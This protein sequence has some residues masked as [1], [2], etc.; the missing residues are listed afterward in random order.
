MTPRHAELL[1][2]DLDDETL[3]RFVDRFLMF[4]IRTAD[5]LQ[6][7]APWVEEKGLEHVREVVCDDSLGLAAEFEAAVARH[8][9]GYAC[10][11][12]GVLEDPDKLSRFVSFVNAPGVDDPTVTITRSAGRLVPTPIGM[13]KVVQR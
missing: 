6:R 12:R 8:V 7:T 9:E 3:V 11:W 10:E 5:R 4:Y 2:S 13:P 1:A